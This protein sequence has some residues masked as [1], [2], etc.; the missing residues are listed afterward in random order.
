MPESFVQSISVF[1]LFLSIHVFALCATGQCAEFHSS[2]AGIEM[3]HGTKT[4]LP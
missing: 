2:P 4:H 3:L 1:M